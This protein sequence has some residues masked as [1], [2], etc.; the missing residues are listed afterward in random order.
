MS[1]DELERR[2]IEGRV[3]E[4]FSGF[5]VPPDLLDW[6]SSYLGTLY[7]F[8]PFSDPDV[9][10]HFGWET[11]ASS[12]GSEGWAYHQEP[13]PVTLCDEDA[14][15]IARSVRRDSLLERL[16]GTFA[17]WRL[18]QRCRL[19]I[20]LIDLGKKILGGDPGE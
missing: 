7:T 16:A 18:S 17:Y 11:E 6:Y 5:I 19:G 14:R 13:H 20:F 15:R 2:T 4:P 1:G 10:I 8:G 3:V 9:K 12:W